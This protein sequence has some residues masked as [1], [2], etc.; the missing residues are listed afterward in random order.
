MSGPALKNWDSHS[1]IHEAAL[2]EAAELTELFRACVAAGEDKRA[3]ELA[4]ITVEHWETRTLQHASAE[5]EGLYREIAAQ[6]PEAQSVIIA[7]TR[8]HTLMRRLVGE[9]KDLLSSGRHWDDIVKRFQALILI[10]LLHNEDEG[11]LLGGGEIS[12]ESTA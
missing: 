9:V 3:L 12:H 4:Y 1:S 8:D 2:S 10:D 7:L 5:E 6:T 11:F